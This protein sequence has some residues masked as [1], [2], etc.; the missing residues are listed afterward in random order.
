M[1]PKSSDDNSALASYSCKIAESA[2][3]F[4]LVLSLP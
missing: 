2:V 1:M 3:S 4:Q